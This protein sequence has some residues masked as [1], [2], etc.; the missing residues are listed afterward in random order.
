MCVRI[1]WKR[2][3]LVSV[4][5]LYIPDAIHLKPNIVLICNWCQIS[6]SILSVCLPHSASYLLN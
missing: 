6:E 1:L 3:Q 2:N 5:W 4:A